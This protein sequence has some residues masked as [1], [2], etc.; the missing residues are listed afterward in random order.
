MWSGLLW[1]VGCYSAGIAVLHLLFGTRQEKP[2]K[3]ARVLLITK[4]NATQI[5]WYI[6][7]L[8]FFSKLKGR[9][10]AATI[11]DEGSTDETM[12]IIERLSQ[13]HMLDVQVCSVNESMDEVMRAHEED[14][15]VVVHISNRA[16]L[17]TIPLFQQ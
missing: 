4:N 12:K 14:D 5:E 11:L 15:W 9:E 10:I 16:D 8:F 17:V 3:K 7:S 2:A 1:I 13:S 6:R